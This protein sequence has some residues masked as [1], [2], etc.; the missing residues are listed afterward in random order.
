MRE[1]AIPVTVVEGVP[2][3]RRSNEELVKIQLRGL[4]GAAP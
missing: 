2:Q 4:L 1:H 3:G